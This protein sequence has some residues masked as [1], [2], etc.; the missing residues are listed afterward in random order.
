MS[1]RTEPTDFSSNGRWGSK[2][3]LKYH[4]A[5]F[6]LAA[7][8]LFVGCA[9]APVRE[10]ATEAEHGAQVWRMTCARCHNLR[11][12]PE[13]TAEQWGVIVNHMRTRQDLTR[14]DA[15][16]VAAFLAEVTRGTGSTR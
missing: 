3:T 10:A 14:S 5:A 7:S 4:T 11:P 8:L 15:E 13:F 16:A 12:A 9:G 6:G 1:S 2:M